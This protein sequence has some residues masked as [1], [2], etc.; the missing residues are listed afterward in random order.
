MKSRLNQQ[1]NR[2]GFFAQAHEHLGIDPDWLY[3]RALAAASCGIIITDA[4]QA[5]H[6]IIY[7]NPAF[8][9]ITGYSRKEVIGR[10]CRF[11]QGL[12]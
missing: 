3:E 10:N 6:P 11:L 4:R 2:S 7:C 12:D 9:K 1:T 5:H 8:E